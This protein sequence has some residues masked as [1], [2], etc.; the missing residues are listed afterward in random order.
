MKD[1]IKEHQ[2]TI[3]NLNKDKMDKLDEEYDQANESS[4]D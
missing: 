3:F 4:P 2:K 1:M